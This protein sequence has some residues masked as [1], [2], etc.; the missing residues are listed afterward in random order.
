[1]GKRTYAYV[2][3]FAITLLLQ[4]IVPSGADNGND[5]QHG[6]Q[7]TRRYERSEL[8][9]LQ[10]GLTPGSDQTIDLPSECTKKDSAKMRKRGKLS[11][12][13]RRIRAR[14]TKPPLPTVMFG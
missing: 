11:G 7:S 6:G 9:Q 3:F 4:Q 8:L 12:L 13:R 1:M 14:D 5:N 2:A 10:H